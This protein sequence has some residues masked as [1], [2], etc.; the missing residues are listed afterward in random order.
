MS[1]ITAIAVPKWGIEMVEGTINVW[2]KT[3]GD[4][5][6][7]GD[8][9]LEMESDKIVNVWESPADGV[10]RRVLVEEGEA[11]PVGALL[12]VIAAAN[13]DDASIDSFIADFGGSAPAAEDDS[14]TDNDAPVPA[15]A[16]NA[17]PGGDAATRSAPA[18]RNL[19]AELGVDL[20]TVTG[21]GRRGRITKDDVRA[22]ASDGAEPAPAGVEVIPLSA[23]R[24]TIAKRLTGA[25]QDI[26]HY[27]LTVNYELDGLLAHR[28]AL[29]ANGNTRVS[30][31]D[32]LVKCVARALQREPR[33]NINVIENSIHQYSDS[34]V[35]VAIAT[36]DGLY[37]VTIRAAQNLSTQEIAA[38]TAEFAERARNG[39]LTR[40]DLSD[41]SFTVSNLGM[42]GIDNFTAI[43][44]P[45]MGAIL[46]LGKG[47][48]QPVVRDGKVTVATIVSATLSC[49]H[50]VIDG[51]IGATFLKVLGEEIASLS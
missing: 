29:N 46:A 1:D 20:N 3:V 2:N 24:Q 8:E 34:N 12:G 28:A 6:A 21:T 47:S 25:K 13:V 5:V 26:P 31:N 39:A 40:E 23:T 45:P 9:I 18:V 35:S 36:E 19:A 42:Y 15:A 7:K 51:A 49:D 11:R 16:A 38:A 4:T 17:G 50:R 22:A 10:L 37:P 30:V 44:N 27:Y 33:V 48:E 43:I 32:L 41:G 14:A